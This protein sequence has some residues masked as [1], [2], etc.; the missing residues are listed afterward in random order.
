M[1]ARRTCPACQ[2][3][4]QSGVRVWFA[5]RTGMREATVCKRCASGGVTIVQDK[6]ADTHACA[7]CERRPAV[8]CSV[9]AAARRNC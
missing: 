5:A 8:F 4:F 7:F 3:S 6:S 9:C 2:R 1:G